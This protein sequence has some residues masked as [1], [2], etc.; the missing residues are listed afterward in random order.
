[1]ILLIL[2]WHNIILI[3]QGTVSSSGCTVDIVRATVPIYLKLF[4]YLVAHHNSPSLGLSHICSNLAAA[5]LVRLFHW[6]FSFSVLSV[7]QSTSSTYQLS[8]LG[9]GLREVLT[10]VATFQNCNF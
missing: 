2:F 1:M 5:L 6:I 10:A 3:Y 8:Q 9:P 4:G 7:C